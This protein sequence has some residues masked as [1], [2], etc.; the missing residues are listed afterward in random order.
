MAIIERAVAEQ[1]GPRLLIL[2]KGA[3]FDAI[4]GWFAAAAPLPRAAGFAIGRSVYWRPAIEYLTGAATEA[5]AVAAVAANY[6]HVIE[7][8]KGAARG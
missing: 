2:G 8:W 1:P 3:G 6:L 5:A 4:Q 7:A